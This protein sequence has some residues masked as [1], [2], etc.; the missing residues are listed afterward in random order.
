MKSLH[1]C[2]DDNI[3]TIF[4]D[5]DKIL[6][7]AGLVHK[8]LQFTLE[9]NNLEGVLVFPDIDVNVSSKNKITCH[10]YRKPTATRIILKFRNWAPLRPK[11][12]VIQWI[13]SQGF[14]AT[15][16]C[17]DFDQAL[18]KNKTCW[19]KNQNPDQWYSKKVNQTL[20]KIIISSNL[21]S[22]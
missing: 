17:L 4:G 5:P 3:G 19:I 15:S 10:W 22:W 2:V 11:K 1:K 9:K 21:T 13:G 14:D 18:E 16:K 8:N 6:I 20:E 7:C 12:N